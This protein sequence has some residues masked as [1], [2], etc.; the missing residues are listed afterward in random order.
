MFIKK[1]KTCGFENI[2]PSFGEIPPSK[3]V[4]PDQDKRFYRVDCTVEN[5]PHWD[6]QSDSTLGGDYAECDCNA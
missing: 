1:C 2:K 6:K 3:R 5:C 4:G